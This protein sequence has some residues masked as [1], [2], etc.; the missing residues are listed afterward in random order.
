MKRV[1]LSICAVCLSL[2]V[3]GGCKNQQTQ[4]YEVMI[5]DGFEKNDGSIILKIYNDATDQEDVLEIED[6]MIKYFEKERDEVAKLTFEDMLSKENKYFDYFMLS[7]DKMRNTGNVEKAAGILKVQTQAVNGTISKPVDHAVS[8]LSWV[9]EGRRHYR[10]AQ[11]LLKEGKKA[12]AKERLEKARDYL[13]IEEDAQDVLVPVI[14]EQ[15][16]ELK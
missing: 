15:L 2:L 7:D 11:D 10:I 8:Q 12:E 3:L 1:I 13:E 16:A 14:N 6:L 9:L 4:N 5:K